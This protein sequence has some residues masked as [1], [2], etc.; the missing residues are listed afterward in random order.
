MTTW[1]RGMK[2]QY[3]RRKYTIHKIDGKALTLVSADGHEY[4]GVHRDDPKLKVVK[5]A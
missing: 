2:V 5:G 4:V 1:K 3:D